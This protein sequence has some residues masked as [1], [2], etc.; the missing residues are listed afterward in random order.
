VK[1]IARRSWG[2]RPPKNRTPLSKA[3]QKGTA[4]HYSGS[5]SDEQADHA[6]CAARVRSIQNF[7]MDVRG[8][9]DIAYSYIICKH[10]YTFECRGLGIRTA[11]QGTNSGNDAFHAACFLGDDSINRDDVTDVGRVAIRDTIAMCNG[12]TTHSDTVRP[13]S[14][15]HPTACP[16]DELRRWISQGMP[17]REE[18]GVSQA[19]V[20][21]ALKSPEGQAELEKAVDHLMSLGLTGDRDGAIRA[22]AMRL[23]S[24]D[25]NLR[26]IM[27]HL[28]LPAD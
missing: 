10:G 25:A 2:A 12:W 28:E 22:W 9:S 20:I 15:F 21:A 7:H 19:D 27:A 13:H 11:A 4:L 3:A 26:K 24:V 1:L 16:G 17:V 23:E 8:W 6:N 5:N 14:W 18:N